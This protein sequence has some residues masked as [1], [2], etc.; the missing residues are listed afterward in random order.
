MA[1]VYGEA[2]EERTIGDDIVTGGANRIPLFHDGGAELTGEDG[3][4]SFSAE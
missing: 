2:R 1:Q 3:S 4:F